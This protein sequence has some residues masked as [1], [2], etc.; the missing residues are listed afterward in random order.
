MQESP[1]FGMQGIRMS[2]CSRFFVFFWRKVCTVRPITTLV[3][4]LAS[5]PITQFLQNIQL[6]RMP[7][8]PKP[9]LMIISKFKRRSPFFEIQYDNKLVK[10]WEWT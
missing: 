9:N 5:G 6:N 7:C 1:V 2:L 10:I 3:S 4:T 8:I